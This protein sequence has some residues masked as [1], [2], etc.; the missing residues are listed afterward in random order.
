MTLNETTGW[1]QKFFRLD[2]FAIALSI[3]NSIGFMLAVGV[4]TYID[5]MYQ[6]AL[7][8]QRTYPLGYHILLLAYP[9][10]LVTYFLNHKET[11]LLKSFH[12]DDKPRNRAVANLMANIGVALVAMPNFAPEIPHLYVFGCSFLS[13]GVTAL[14]SYFHFTGNLLEF[15]FVRN[16]DLPANVKLAILRQD[17]DFWFAALKVFVTIALSLAGA[18]AINVFVLYGQVFPTNPKA[19]TSFALVQAFGSIF[20]IVFFIFGILREILVRMEKYRSHLFE[21]RDT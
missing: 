21:I 16:E 13:G 2:A 14:S 4:P 18:Y 9:V 17:F 8:P 1:N 10:F 11:N 3:L 6:S 7:F 5:P 19:A 15:G 20:Y 12:V